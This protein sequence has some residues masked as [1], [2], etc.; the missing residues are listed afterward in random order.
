M[1]IYTRVGDKGET[2]LIGGVSTDKTDLRVVVCGELDELNAVIG[3]AAS[4]G[5]PQSIGETIANVQEALFD[6]GAIVASTGSGSRRAPECD[7]SL[8]TQELERS[9][10]R[11]E[12]VLRPLRSFIL[13]GGSLP[14]ASLHLARTV[15]RRC[16]RQHLALSKAFPAESPL[17]ALQ[18]WLNRLSDWLFVAARLANHEAGVMEARWLPGG[19]NKH[20]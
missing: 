9:I 18:P 12:E 4:Y 7:W 15:C 3:L 8:R 13:P 16:E 5:L 17:V 20:R 19:S 1:K 14:G 2:R 11:M 10:D 6:A